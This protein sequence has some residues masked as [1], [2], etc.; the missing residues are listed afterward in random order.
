MILDGNQRGNSKNLAIHLLKEENER[1]DV[2]EIRG[3][4]VDNL[5]GAFQESYA[6][7]R[8]TKCKQH[9]FS[10]SLNPPKNTSPTVEE[11]KA[12][13]NKTEKQLGLTDQPRVIVFYEKFGIDGKLRRHAHA[14]WC[15]IDIENMKA[16]QLSFSHKKLR[17]ISREIFVKHNWQMPEGLKDR[18]NRDPRNFTLAEWQQAK[19]AGKNPKELK[20]LFQDCWAFSDG[21]TAFVNAILEQG[22]VLAQGK[23]GHVAVDYQGEVYPISKW[24]GKKVKGIREIL[25]NIESLPS[26]EKAQLIASKI[27]TVRLEELKVQE[28]N[29]VSAK[30]NEGAVEA[31]HLKKQQK[32][33]EIQLSDDLFKRHAQEK[34]LRSERIRT[35][36]IGFIDCFT[37]R[38]KRTLEENLIET[39]AM[40]ERD[41][42]EVE[43]L[44]STQ[45][46][47]WQKHLSEVET[48]QLQHKKH[49]QELSHDITWLAPP[50]EVYERKS[51]EEEQR[52]FIPE[53]VTAPAYYRWF[54]MMT[55]W[56]T[57]N[58]D[59]SESK[60]INLHIRQIIQHVQ[61]LKFLR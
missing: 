20:A 27:I 39:V 18:K 11:F 44:K 14:V 13:I 45:C 56:K 28:Q 53:N 36:V 59:C 40:H 54:Q 21:K 7:S 26:V 48:A 34:I 23:R 42:Y 32:K 30:R 1:V 2:H 35:G 3:F 57:L 38:R 55:S 8:A 24:V 12:A 46:R 5:L 25:G 37:G 52:K 31:R 17:E 22:F 6:I 49:V 9:L 4:V 15:R 29:V 33:T 51:D 50:T 10:L 41:R 61:M 60:S 58:I 43:V 16:I 19:R 47:D